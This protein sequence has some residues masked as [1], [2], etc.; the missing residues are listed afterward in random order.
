M[1]KTGIKGQ[2]DEKA[3]KLNTQRDI[4]VIQGNYRTCIRKDHKSD[5]KV[6]SD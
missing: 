6:F 1:G 2:R 5:G 4:G 3:N